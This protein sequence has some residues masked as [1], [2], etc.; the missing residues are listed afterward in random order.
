MLTRVSS[1]PSTDLT[2]IQVNYYSCV[3]LERDA[4]GSSPALCSLLSDWKTIMCKHEKHCR[5]AAH[6]FNEFEYRVGESL[7]S[8]C[9][10]CMLVVQSRK[11][12][13]L[14]SS[15]NSNLNLKRFQWLNR[16]ATSPETLGNQKEAHGGAQRVFRCS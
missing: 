8:H 7:Q 5:F 2:P 6:R 9:K 16:F 11:F 14:A 1:L 15:W 12:A 10:C 13:K 4:I 3:H